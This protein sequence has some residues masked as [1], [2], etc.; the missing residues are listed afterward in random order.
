MVTDKRKEMT[1]WEHKKKY[2]RG[3][4][5]VITNR[6]FFFTNG[7]GGFFAFNIPGGDVEYP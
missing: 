2:R 5:T 7:V 6:V 4:K 1:R 3:S